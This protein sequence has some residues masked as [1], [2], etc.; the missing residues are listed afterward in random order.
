[1]KQP[2]IQT[3]EGIQFTMLEP[4]VED[5]NI[6]DIAHALSQEP[7]FGGHAKHHYSVAQHCVNLSKFA[8]GRLEKLRRLLH[9]A[10]EA[11]LKD[12]PRPYKYA[13]GVKKVLR[14]IEA[15]MEVAVAA[16]F[17]LELPLVGAAVKRDD[18]IL[19]ATEAW[20]LMRPGHFDEWEPSPHLDRVDDEVCADLG[21]D[22]AYWPDELA[23]LR[24]L[25][26]FIRL[27]EGT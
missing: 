19:L 15:R 11:Y 5:I 25:Q 20:H 18:N 1:M 9:D 12:I 13:P 21:L 26:Q 17:G 22:F 6:L 8:G 3:Y 2:W 14:P 23:E 10:P 16:R 4:R 7:R 24:Y 27:T